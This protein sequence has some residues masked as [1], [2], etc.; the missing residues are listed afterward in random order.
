M[1]LLVQCCVVEDRENEANVRALLDMSEKRGHRRGA[2]LLL[3]WIMILVMGAGCERS[4]G[5]DATLRKRVKQLGVRAVEPAPGRHAKEK[6]ELGRLLFFEPE[7]SG[8]RDTSCATCH[9]PA[10]AM[11]DGRALSVGTGGEGVGPA[12]IGG[13][14][15][16]HAPRN[17]QALFNVNDS[18]WRVQFWDG[19]VELFASGEVRTPVSGSLPAGLESVVAAQ[20]M[21]PVLSRDEM[22][23]ER[24]DVD[25]RGEANE[26]AEAFNSDGQRV[27]RGIMTR[28]LEHEGYREAFATIYPEV[29]PRALGFEHAANAMAA[30]QVEEL[31]LSNS[32]W[33]R[34]LRGDDKALSEQAKRGALL[35]YGEAGCGSC[36]AGALMTDQKFYNIGVPQLGPGKGPDQPYDQGRA[37]VSMDPAEAFMFRTP[38]LRHVAWTAPYM[39]NGA[40]ATLEEAIKHHV[41]PR[42]MVARY[43]ASRIEDESLRETVQLEPFARDMVLSGLS[44]ELDVVPELSDVQV[45]DLI[46]FLEACGD[47]EVLELERLVPEKLPS[48]LMVQRVKE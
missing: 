43:D 12:R 44:E 7:L 10:L 29:H 27:W 31:S 17:A 11:G 13:K 41:D 28:L 33:D 8:N 20:A 15:R 24:G 16:E 19:R 2:S 23:G 38:P 36:H 42:G 37:R 22:R 3:I 4:S 1:A 6:V 45:N 46:V 34:Y 9:H 30:F 25:V 5:V 26:L 39:H 35:F 48:G 32:P 40:Y 21:F 47:P 14:G 18:S